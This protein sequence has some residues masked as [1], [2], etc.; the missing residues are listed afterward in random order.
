LGCGAA[1][2]ENVVSANAAFRI[3]LVLALGA[4]LAGACGE[5]S[6]L[7][8]RC[9]GGD[10]AVC[11]QLGEMYATGNRV[12]RDLSRAVEMY[13]Q[14]CNHGAV[15]VCNTLGEIY[16][17]GHELEGGLERAEQLFRFACNGNSAAGCLNLGLALASRD[18]KKAAAQLFERSCSAGWTP[19]C[20]HLALAFDRGEG[21]LVDLNR[22][23]GLY[24]EACATKFV[25]SCLALGALYI[26]GDRVERDVVRASRY[27]GTAL[28]VYDEGCQAGSETDCKERDKLR[29]RVAIL[30]ATSR[31]P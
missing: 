21:V 26:A 29:T 13:Q 5:A 7:R 6:R 9:M 30:T 17:R 10:D 19:G 14:A 28:K 16:E 11:I 18:D 15:E 4:A 25:D 3:P 27:Y 24:E 2:K 8:A 31:R 12:P 20:H 22:A 23:I 1:G